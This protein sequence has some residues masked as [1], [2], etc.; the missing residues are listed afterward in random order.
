MGMI[1]NNA[2]LVL[3]NGNMTNVFF[4]IDSYDMHDMKQLNRQALIDDLNQK[5]DLTAFG[6]WRKP[7]HDDAD[8]KNTRLSAS[9]FTTSRKKETI[10]DFKLH[11]VDLHQYFN[12][13]HLTGE[14]KSLKTSFED[15]KNE[16]GLDMKFTEVILKFGSYGDVTFSVHVPIRNV[17]LTIQMYHKVMT[18][19]R[20]VTR[21]VYINRVQSILH[22]FIDTIYEAPKKRYC[23]IL[24]ENDLEEAQKTANEYVDSQLM[25]TLIWTHLIYSAYYQSE[26]SKTIAQ[27]IAFGEEDFTH[28]HHSTFTEAKVYIGWSNTVILMP[29]EKLNNKDHCVAYYVRPIENKLAEWYFIIGINDHLDRL[30]YQSYDMFVSKKYFAI[31]TTKYKNQMNELLFFIERIMQSYDNSAITLNQFQ[32]SVMKGHRERWDLETYFQTYHRKKEAL[33]QTIDYV[34]ENKKAMQGR[35]L[36]S[37]LFV[38]ALF[39]VIDISSTIYRAFTEGDEF[40]LLFGLGPAASI[41]IIIFLYNRIAGN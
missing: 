11:A 31:K 16:T 4:D 38:I 22:T 12:R 18:Y 37:I 41:L 30:L 3:M 26:A 40:L 39:S 36:N 28:V 1:I 10:I 8:E 32:S 24:I 33:Y 17:S 25:D 35:V 14:E 20:K 15:I 21:H 5:K 27:K 23:L 9:A 34:I 13:K 7:N 29:E 19:I 6:L 2:D